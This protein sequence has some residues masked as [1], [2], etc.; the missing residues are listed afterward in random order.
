MGHEPVPFPW[1]TLG[2]AASIVILGLLLFSAPVWPATNS[3][4]ITEKAGV[5]T[6]NYPIQI[7]RPFVQGEVPNYPQV[8]INGTVVTTQADVK[9]RWPDG[10]AKHAILTFYIPTLQ[11]GSTITVTF[12]N[13]GSGNNAGYA[14]KSDMLGTGYN[15]DAT[16]QLTGSTI[17]NASARTMLNAGAFTYWLQGSI[18]T[19][20]I[21]AD[22]SLSRTYD[23]GFDSYKAFRPIFHATFWPSINKVRV[24]FVGEIA[25][26]EAL[27]N[28]TYSL[29]LR[30]GSASPATVYSKSAFT[31]YAGTRWTKEVW[32]GTPPSSIAI[33]HNLAYLAQTKLVPNYDVSKVV[34]EA[35]L[36][37]AYA[38]WT[39][40]GKDLFAAGNWMLDMS[41]PG[42]RQDIG[43]Y[44][45][46]TVQWLYSGDVRLKEKAFGNA[47]LA[48]AWPMHY[49]E[50]N[51]AKYVDRSRTVN[52]VGRVLSVSTRP[53][54]TLADLSYSYTVAA[55]RVVPVGTVSNGGWAPDDAHTPDPFSPQYLLSGDFWYLEELYFWASWGAAVSNGAAYEYPEGRGPTGA[56]GGIPGQI[57]GQAWTLRNRVHAASLAPDGAPEKAYFETLIADA[58]AI[59]EGGLNITAS[60][61]NATANWNWGRTIRTRWWPSTIPPLHHWEPGAALFVQ[62]C[63]DPAVT[64]AALSP[65]EQNFMMFA[66]GRAKE[67]GYRSDLLV[68]WLG[69]NVIGQIIGSGYDP[70]LSGAYRIPVR[71]VSDGGY[72]GTWTALRAGFLATFSAD[73]T[74]YPTPQSYWNTF[75]TDGDHGY[76]LIA[77]AAV[78]MAATESGG[79][80]A[81]NW[82]AQ[83]ALTAS[84][85]NDNPKWAILPRNIT[86]TP[87]SAPSN[88]LVR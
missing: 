15:F 31:H 20:I 9:S 45:T 59:W 51:G 61:A 19:S 42:G 58:I 57:R 21:L 8:L 18:A 65:W 17:Q 62:T 2:R 43:P 48:A 55:D 49:R 80:T 13:Q 84:V 24:R 87:P 35:T 71:R 82:M 11:A 14:T 37:Y 16:M 10:S 67:L 3:L 26:T 74:Y 75:V 47:D 77:L 68:S 73:G 38:Q 30:T 79:S 69:V 66:L 64:S 40:A 83:N 12:Q 39:T 46:W 34:S 44:P 70:Y 29:V 25:N 1:K 72:F 36:A 7:G 41:S 5:T 63:I 76:P 4:T 32:M 53:T 85:L 23:I 54:L 78:A 88:L 27:E 81:W 56:E 28:Q 60:P 6:S 22:H 50:G 86:V 52:G 33:D